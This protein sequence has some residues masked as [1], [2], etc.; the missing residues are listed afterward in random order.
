[1]FQKDNY[2]QCLRKPYSALCILISTSFDTGLTSIFHEKPW[3][4]K[5]LSVED[6]EKSTIT[7]KQPPLRHQA[8]ISL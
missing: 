5:G 3:I 1:M 4:L 2:L 7:S 8:E 6:Q